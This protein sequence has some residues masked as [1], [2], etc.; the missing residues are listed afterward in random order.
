M[1][2]IEHEIATRLN[3]TVRS[4]ENVFHKFMDAAGDLAVN[5]VVAVIILTVT[6]WAA[7]WAA[8]L[9][10]RLI[11]R[12]HGGGPP[13]VTLQGFAG[14]AAR[15]LVMIV[16]II[17][18]LQQLGVQ[19]TSILAVLGAASLAVG[20]A[21]QGTLSNVA[22]GVMLLLFRPY[23]VGDV[24]EVAGRTGTVRTL[25]LFVT[26]LTTPDNLKVVLPNGKVF[27]DV[28]VNTSYHSRRRVD[29]VIK[30][31]LKRDVPALME[32]LKARAEANP[33]VLKDPAPAVE[34][35][36]MSEAFVEVTVRAWVESGDFGAVKADM[37]LAGRFLAEGA[38]QLPALPAP[39]A[40]PAAPKKKARP[41]LS[42]R[43]RAKP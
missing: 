27:G 14:S 25:D 26:E 23:R 21:L 2:G 29:A 3:Q 42:D 34:L 33:L 16:G 30:T 8:R 39:R 15:Y 9:V 10:R 32:G 22:A 40:K 18:V 5:L 13:D 37:M 17:A 38:E 20:L 24:I 1:Q 35:T 41:T 12:V 7:G 43:L 31:D 6:W 19:T 11:A 28:I 4:D 36:G